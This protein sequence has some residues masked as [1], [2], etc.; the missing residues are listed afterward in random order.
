ML[1]PSLTRR[2][3]RDAA[4]ES[5]S[6]SRQ[7]ATYLPSGCKPRCSTSS[8]RSSDMSIPISPSP[9]SQRSV[10]DVTISLSATGSSR[11]KSSLTTTTRSRSRRRA[12]GS[13]MVT[14]W[15]SLQSARTCLLSSRFS[16][17]M[18]ARRGCPRRLRQSSP[19]GLPIR[20]LCSPTMAERSG[21][22]P[23]CRP[24]RGARVRPNRSRRR[25]TSSARPLPRPSSWISLRLRPWRS[26]AAR[27]TPIAM[28]PRPA[29]SRC[30][31]ITTIRRRRSSTPISRSSRS[32]TVWNIPRRSRGISPAQAP[33]SA[34]IRSIPTSSRGS[35]P[36]SET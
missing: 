14:T 9:I 33:H 8:P 13:P 36:S 18:T 31:I 22:T 4:R 28:I 7:R 16:R 19:E 25:R 29:P 12:S 34:R 35:R 5:G 26:R 23:A 2:W 20:S 24:R 27:S 3:A 30:S 11:R 6:L 32:L 1:S 15:R 21:R 10:A 17:T